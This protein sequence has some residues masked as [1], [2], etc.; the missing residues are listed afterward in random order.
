MHGWLVFIIL[1]NTGITILGQNAVNQTAKNNATS[2]EYKNPLDLA[3][4]PALVAVLF[5][6]LCASVWLLYI[7]FFNSRLFGII[8]TKIVNRFVIQD[9]AYFQ[10][11][12]YLFI[13]SFSAYIISFS[14]KL[15]NVIFALT[16]S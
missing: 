9:D 7:T 4:N 11:G 12:M 6:S 2:S 16:R 8:L 13:I 14:A 3:N 5:A 1:L 15:T 10:V